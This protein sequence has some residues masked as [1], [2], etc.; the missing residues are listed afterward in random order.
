MLFNTLFLLSDN[1]AREEASDLIPPN[2]ICTSRDEI[3]DLS[4]VLVANIENL[5][6]LNAHPNTHTHTPDD[7]ALPRTTSD[8]LMP[9]IS[10]PLSIFIPV[11]C[12]SV[13]PYWERHS[14]CSPNSVTAQLVVYK[15]R[16]LKEHDGIPSKRRGDFAFSTYCVRHGKNQHNTYCVKHEKNLDFRN[17]PCTSCLHGRAIC[18]FWLSKPEGCTIYRL[19][20]EKSRTDFV[21]TVTLGI[22]S[23]SGLQEQ[24]QQ[25]SFEHSLR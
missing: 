25:P 4:A 18:G 6:T 16:S 14:T 23:A 2:S 12:S 19:G 17:S 21:A 11:T 3:F 15:T 7:M 9:Y 24:Q 20:I 1:H 5:L 22:I 8:L 10:L 13:F